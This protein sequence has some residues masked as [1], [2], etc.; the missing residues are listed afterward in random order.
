[1]DKIVTIGALPMKWYRSGVVKL[2]QLLE[3]YDG[4]HEEEEE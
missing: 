2:T 3:K 4:D 1:L